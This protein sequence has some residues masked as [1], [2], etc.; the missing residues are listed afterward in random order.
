MNENMHKLLILLGAIAVVLVLVILLFTKNSP[1]MKLMRNFLSDGESDGSQK[2]QPIK[3]KKSSR[4]QQKYNEPL[5]E[6]ATLVRKCDDRL[7]II[8]SSG[9][10][11]FIDEYYELI[12]RTRKGNNLKIQCSREAYERIPFNQQGSLTYKNS[13]LIRFK[14]YDGVVNN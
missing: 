13:K 4:P 8:E 9:Q 6:M 5:I 2:N 12:F 3:K 14:F 11:R 7:R 1:F 10:V